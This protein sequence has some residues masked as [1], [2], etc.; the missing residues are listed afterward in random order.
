MSQIIGYNL[1][2]LW[3]P[4]IPLEY[5]LNSTE[6]SNFRNY[7]E[8]ATVTTLLEDCLDSMGQNC[9]ANGGVCVPNL[10][11]IHGNYS[12]NCVPLQS[13]S[14]PSGNITY[15]FAIYL[16]I[17]VVS[18]GVQAESSLFDWNYPNNEPLLTLSTKNNL[19]QGLTPYIAEVGGTYQQY[20][21]TFTDL[22]NGQSQ[23]F[24][25]NVFVCPL[26]ASPESMAGNT[27][28]ENSCYRLLDTS[29]TCSTNYLSAGNV[30]AIRFSLV[31][32]SPTVYNLTAIS[33]KQL[34]Y[35]SNTVWTP[36]LSPNSTSTF[37][38]VAA[39]YNVEYYSS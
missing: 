8:N 28:L 1:R 16:Q 13:T 36:S 3:D 12:Y 20:Q 31:N 37:D 26:Y 21:V 17:T 30:G 38:Q 4:A 27:A 6:A 14:S 35:N 23:T 2:P 10:A 15:K 7:I 34:H 9:T 11:S 39:Y 32:T 18:S 29:G 5:F 25:P 24:C 33:S 22:L 19:Q